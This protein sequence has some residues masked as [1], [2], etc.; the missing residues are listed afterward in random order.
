M[1]VEYI[2]Y[3]FK[4]KELTS[5]THFD[6]SFLEYL[7]NYNKVIV[8]QDGGN[9]YMIYDTF[10]KC[11]LSQGKKDFFLSDVFESVQFVRN[12][13]TVIGIAIKHNDGYTENFRKL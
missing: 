1:G 5:T 11:L 2:K 4:A 3:L 10:K 12:D 8:N 7:G 13:K 6:K 9:L